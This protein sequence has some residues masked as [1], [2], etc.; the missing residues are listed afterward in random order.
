[1]KRA[2]DFRG[3]ARGCL[4]GHWASAVGTTLLA[5][6]LGA[7]ITMQGNVFSLTSN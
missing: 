5:G 2:A 6:L 3:I 7:N 1:M 4:S